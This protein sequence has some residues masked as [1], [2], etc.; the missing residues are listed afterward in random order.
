MMLSKRVLT[1]SGKSIVD[2]HKVDYNAQMVFHKLALQAQS[3]TQAVL[4]G[5]RM[6]GKL[7]T[8]RYDPKSGKTAMSFINAFTKM[9]NDYNDQQLDVGMRLNGPM[10]KSMLMA[11]LSSV[12]ML[13]SISD[14][15]QERVVQGGKL[16]TYEEY[17]DLMKSTATLFDENMVSRRSNTIEIHRV[18]DAEL[19]NEITEFY[20]NEMKRRVPGSAMNKETWNSLSQEG[21]TIWDKLTDVDKKRILQ[22]ALKRA[23]KDK[24]AVNNHS[25]DITV[26]EEDN[27]AEDPKDEEGAH[28]QAEIHTAVSKARSEAHPG[29]PRR[30]LGS[31]KTKSKSRTSEVKMVNWGVDND[32][33]DGANEHIDHAVEDYWQSDSSSDG[34]DFW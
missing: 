1:E 10:K 25:M 8:Q 27:V 2:E 21:K 24:I 17:L 18:S 26:L 12:T 13:R 29:D 19:S 34:E 16:F 7:T 22:Y 28:T 11:S 33:D 15:E 5:R 30:M 6:M 32:S 20:V 3:S 23:E 9:V 4:S 31:S 14:R